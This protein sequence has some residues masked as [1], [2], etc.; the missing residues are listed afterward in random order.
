MTDEDD[1]QVWRKETLR[2]WRSIDRLE[3]ATAANLV[4]GA[5]LLPLA[6]LCWLGMAATISVAFIVEAYQHFRGCET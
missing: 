5:L 1:Y 4:L 6:S 3:Q 2:D